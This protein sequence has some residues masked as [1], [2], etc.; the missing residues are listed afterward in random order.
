MEPPVPLPRRSRPSRMS[1]ARHGIA[2]LTLLSLAF[3]IAAAPPA[4]ATLDV[5]V[6]LNGNIAT[7]VAQVGAAGGGTVTLKAGTYNLTTP[8]LIQ[9]NTTIIGQG[10]K[11]IILAPA[12]PHGWSMIQNASEGITNLTFENLVIDGNIPR[13]AYLPTGD[14]PYAGAGIYLFAYTY[15]ITNVTITNV[16]I[17]NAGLGMLTG[18]VNGLNMQNDNIHDNDPGS[19]AHNAYLVATYDVT[20]SHCRFDNSHGG[21]GLH[22]DFGASNY[23]I[24]K[25]EFSGN[26][27]EGILDEGNAGIVIED[28]VMNFNGLT[29]GGNG[30]NGIDAYSNN[31]FDT[32]LQTNY[33]GQY[34]IQHLGGTGNFTGF[35]TLGNAAGP[36]YILGVG[37]YGTNVT[38]V[39]FGPTAN[40]YPAVL[41]QGALGPADTADWTTQ[42]PGYTTLGE[43][44]FD[45]NHL[46]NG[47]L[48]F[49]NV[50]VV[51]AGTYQVSLRYANGAGQTLA[52]P[53]TV[54]GKSAGTLSFPPTTSWSSWNTITAYLALKDGPNTLQV[55]AQSAGAPELDELVVNTTV[56]SPPASAC[57]ITATANSP[58][59]VTLAWPA[60][61]GASGYAVLRANSAGGPFKPLA[62]TLTAKTYQDTEILLGGATY[63][64]QVIA[65]NE[66]GNATPCTISVTTPVDAPAGLQ[67]SAS[68][69]GVALNWITANGALSYNIKRS[70]NGRSFTTIANIPNTTSPDT[71]NFEQTYTDTTA[72]NGVTYTYE[73]SSVGPQGESGNS[74]T[75]TVPAYV[76]TVVKKPV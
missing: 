59:A 50:G 72:D 20:I 32:R 13:G 16:E 29:P 35:E 68:S 33:N 6:P 38:N 57:P 63:D 71:S 47:K 27:G 56:P 25:S 58:Y 53:L 9:S 46:T 28:S 61:P 23:T 67:G 11:T 1:K 22:F 41:A 4:H 45:A 3:A 7:Y 39:M 75:V 36:F 43:V 42:Y 17:R 12:T 65:Y 19:F 26:V 64:Y 55:T 44:D 5:T 48:T 62:T 10:A 70:K 30:E 49:Q 18:T 8:I 14:S 54:N 31:L 51:G 2:K 15:A 37:G 73:V 21:D 66:G 69:G 52:M 76:I 74:Y 60:I 24:S 40:V 34:G